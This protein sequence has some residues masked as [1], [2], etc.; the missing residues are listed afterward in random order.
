MTRFD[1]ITEE[2]S[3]VY[4]AVD[5]FVYD[6]NFF[7]VDVDDDR[8]QGYRTVTASCGCCSDI[9]DYE[10]ELSYEVEYMD[11]ADFEELIDELRK[12]K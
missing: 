7:F 12:L 2:F 8:I 4:G 3:G 10:T 6:T 1:R 9:V 5:M 11:D